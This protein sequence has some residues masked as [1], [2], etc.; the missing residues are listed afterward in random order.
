MYDTCYPDFSDSCRAS[1]T[2]VMRF[3]RLIDKPYRLGDTVHSYTSIFTSWDP[4]GK[5]IVPMT[6][7]HQG[8]LNGIT[9]IVGECTCSEENISLPL[10]TG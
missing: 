6:I 5:Q 4:S 9:G 7:S 8:L 2:G 10:S 3:L 1:Q